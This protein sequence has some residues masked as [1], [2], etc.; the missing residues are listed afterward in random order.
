MELGSLRIN[1]QVFTKE[2]AVPGTVS[3]AV[4]GKGRQ[5]RK[6]GY[7][8]KSPDTPPRPY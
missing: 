3:D 4:R 2:Q 1:Q 5:T 6:E 8:L 7:P